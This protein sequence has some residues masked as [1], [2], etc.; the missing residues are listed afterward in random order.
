M[1][2]AKISS[3]SNAGARGRP[4]QPRGGAGSIASPDC[5]TGMTAAAAIQISVTVT[6]RA[7]Q[8]SAWSPDRL[9]LFLG[10]VNRLH[11]VARLDKADIDKQIAQLIEERDK[12]DRQLERAERLAMEAR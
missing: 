6:L 7:E 5:I 2:A 12:T 9:T 3:G 1:R 11:A 10:A 4:S 8:V